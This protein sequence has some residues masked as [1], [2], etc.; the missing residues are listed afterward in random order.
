[1]NTIEIIKGSDNDLKKFGSILGLCIAAIFGIIIPWINKISFPNAYPIWPWVCL[2]I[3]VGL[4]VTFPRIFN[5]LY[6]IWIK[7]GLFMGWVNTRVI[8]FIL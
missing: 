5:P 6:L 7:F 1:M 4:S 3:V 8:L 2:L